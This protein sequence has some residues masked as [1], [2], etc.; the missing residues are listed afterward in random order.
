GWSGR[1]LMVH[2]VAWQMVALD[3]AKELAVA[4]RSPTKEQADADWEAR[5]GEVVNAEVEARWAG[6]PLAEVRDEFRRVAGELRGFLTV[7]PESR[8]IKHS[9]HQ[10]F[11]VDET[12]DHYD[13]HR[14]DLA[15]ILAAAGR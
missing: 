5:G 1:D 12:L 9:D 11:F 10:R 13:E 7:V 8:W 6:R 14:A 15:A 3:V 4:D 2:L